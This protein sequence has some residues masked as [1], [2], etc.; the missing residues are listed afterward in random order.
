MGGV[1]TAGSVARRGAGATEAPPAGRR[2][3]LVGTAPFRLVPRVVDRLI[4][5]LL[6]WG[7]PP[8][9]GLPGEAAVRDGRASVQATLP[10]P[11]AGGV[12]RTG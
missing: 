4:G 6:G 12:M 5:V 10:P 2:V 8:G 3:R 1:G 11:A 9:G 7:P